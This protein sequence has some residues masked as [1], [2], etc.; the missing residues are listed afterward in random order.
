M[1][2]S[3]KINFFLNKNHS[4]KTHYHSLSNEITQKISTFEKNKFP[5]L[6]NLLKLS[7]SNEVIKSIRNLSSAKSSRSKLRSKFTKI[8]LNDNFKKL[9]IIEAKIKH[10]K[11]INSEIDMLLNKNEIDLNYYKKYNINNK[12][13]NNNN[14]I[15]EEEEKI[16]KIKEQTITINNFNNINNNNILIESSNDEL[17]KFISLIIK[18]NKSFLNNYNIEETLN[19]SN[20]N[21][22]NNNKNE[23]INNK[24]ISHSKSEKQ[25]IEYKLP[26]I[27]EYYKS[28]YNKNFKEKKKKL[29]FKGSNI[30]QYIYNNNNYNNYNNN[31]NNII[32]LQ[33]KNKSSNNLFEKNFK[34]N[35]INHHKNY[36]IN[37]IISNS[38]RNKLHISEEDQSN[39]KEIKKGIENVQSMANKLE[40]H[41]ISKKLKINNLNLNLYKEKKNNKSFLK[42][43]VNNNCVKTTLNN[44]NNN[45]NSYLKGK[46]LFKKRLEK[47]NFKNFINNHKENMKKLTR[48][49]SGIILPSIEKSESYLITKNNKSDLRHKKVNSNNSKKNIFLEDNSKIL[50]TN[51]NYNK[52]INNNNKCNSCRFNLKNIKKNSINPI[53]I[54]SNLLD[55]IRNNYMNKK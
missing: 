55:K 39:I 44:N 49:N 3:N 14:K 19:K 34:S 2:S 37:N 20:Y 23:N 16:N 35:F 22:N 7:E 32:K 28:N 13:G 40:K 27:T 12:F 45:D 21:N 5:S 46:V 10:L 48:F 6:K 53:R 52:K 31:Y 33:S 50:T 36:K 29:S 1:I 4:K 38:Q 47:S 17:N 51:K 9:D 11:R 42:I 30:Y 54:K 24:K 8:S 26:F 41:F 43:K 25:F 18:N 15:K